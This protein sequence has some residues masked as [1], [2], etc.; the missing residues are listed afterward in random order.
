MN[1]YSFEHIF[2]CFFFRLVNKNRNMLTIKLSN[3]ISDKKEKAWFG[4]MYH[5]SKKY[6]HRKINKHTAWKKQIS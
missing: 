2:P 1:I 5:L 4:L 6:S 3:G